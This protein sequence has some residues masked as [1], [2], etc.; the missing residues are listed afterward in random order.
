MSFI[1]ENFWIFAVVAI[2]VVLYFVDRYSK[3]KTQ[4]QAELLS[5]KLDEFGEKISVEGPQFAEMRELS[6]AASWEPTL[7]DAR[8]FRL[9]GKTAYFLFGTYYAYKTQALVLYLLVDVGSTQQQW[10]LSSTYD[11]GMA[12]KS[13]DEYTSDEAVKRFSKGYLQEISAVLFCRPELEIP[14]TQA[15]QEA[16][17]EDVLRFMK[18]SYSVEGFSRYLLVSF[19]FNDPGNLDDATF[20][21]IQDF[22]RL[23]IKTIVPVV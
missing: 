10:L 13:P 22:A 15:L 3:K 17:R 14:I 23:T 11:E 1:Q 7:L 4:A 16:S 8:E 21:R 12:E 9:D 5:R 19:Y 2:F 20:S 18:A 6:S